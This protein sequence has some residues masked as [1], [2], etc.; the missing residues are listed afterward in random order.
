MSADIEVIVIGVPGMPGPGAWGTPDVLAVLPDQ[1]ANDAWLTVI[2]LGSA[3]DGTLTLP[4]VPVTSRPYAV[5]WA[6][7]TNILTVVGD[8]ATTIDDGASYDIDTP[9][10]FAVFAFDGAGWWVIGKG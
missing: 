3:A 8:N 7:A 2:Q 6:H 5:K 9:Y 10:G 4:D 1:V